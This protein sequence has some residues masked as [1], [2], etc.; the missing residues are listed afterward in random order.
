M[1]SPTKLSQ[2]AVVSLPMAQPNGVPN[3]NKQPAEDWLRALGCHETLVPEL[4]LMFRS[5]ISLLPLLRTIVL[6][7]LLSYWVPSGDDHPAFDFLP[8]PFHPDSHSLSSTSRAQQLSMA[9]NGHHP[10]LRPRGVDEPLPLKIFVIGAG[11]SG[12]LA[13]ASPIKLVKQL[14]LV[15]YDTNEELCAAWLEL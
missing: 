14:E 15:I 5:L 7:L 10:V 13:I 2:C 3:V 1:S 11:Q 9:Q 8:L 6:L 4:S 12:I